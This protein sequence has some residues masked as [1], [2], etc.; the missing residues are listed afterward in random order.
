MTDETVSYEKEILE[1]TSAARRVISVLERPE[2]TG[3]NATEAAEGYEATRTKWRL[4]FDVFLWE[5][6]LQKSMRGEAKEKFFQLVSALIDAH[7]DLYEVAT[8]KWTSGNGDTLDTLI[9]LPA[10]G[11]LQGGYIGLALMDDETGSRP[12]LERLIRKGKTNPAGHDHWVRDAIDILEM[13][14]EM[15]TRPSPATPN[16]QPK[17]AGTK[18]KAAV[19]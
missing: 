11:I 9:R 1:L 8:E 14:L 18:G 17:Q 10:L 13:K 15:I 3:V 2:D 12:E 4:L 16:Q 7:L 5:P 6:D 19:R